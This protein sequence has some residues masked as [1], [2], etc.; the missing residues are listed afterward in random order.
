[1]SHKHHRPHHGGGIGSMLAK[2][3]VT[4]ALSAAQNKLTKRPALNTPK[5][6]GGDTN[7]KR[8]K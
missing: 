6:D 1:M 4:V 3:A 5:S 2:L 8:R 7:G